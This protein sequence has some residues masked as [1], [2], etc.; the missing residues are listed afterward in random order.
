MDRPDFLTVTVN[1]LNASISGTLISLF[2]S[3]IVLDTPPA[4]IPISLEIES[5]VLPLRY[6]C[7]TSALV[8]RAG[9]V[10][11]LVQ[12]IMIKNLYKENCNSRRHFFGQRRQTTSHFRHFFRQSRHKSR[13]FNNPSTIVRCLSRWWTSY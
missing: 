1:S 13:H 5:L 7:I 4:E 9:I 10:T 6:P 11:Y 12:Y 2:Y 8:G 3:F